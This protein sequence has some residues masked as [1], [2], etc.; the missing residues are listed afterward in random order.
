MRNKNY[1]ALVLASDVFYRFDI[2]HK[3]G[4]LIKA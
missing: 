1:D 2:V 4:T 3:M